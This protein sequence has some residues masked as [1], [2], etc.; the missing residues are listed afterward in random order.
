MASRVFSSD[1]ISQLVLFIRRYMWPSLREAGFVL[2]V[3][4]ASIFVLLLMHLLTTE[5]A[6]LSFAMIANVIERNVK[7]SEV[8]VY[9]LAL[10][11]P[12]AWIMMSHWQ[13]RRH[14]GLYW[15]LFLIQ[16]AI[17]LGSAIVYSMAKSGG[18]TNTPFADIWATICVIVGIII[19]YVTLVYEKW[20]PRT[21]EAPHEESGKSILEDLERGE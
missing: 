17:V 12:A 21:G 3:S 13:G 1:Q 9:V 10:V 4:N 8:L 7:S 6:S 19:W 14:I 15:I 18:I 11:A 2:I 5:G 16:G 20:L